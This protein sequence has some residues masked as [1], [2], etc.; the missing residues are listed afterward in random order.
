MDLQ[1]L[2]SELC[3]QAVALLNTE[4]VSGG[5]SCGCRA[6]GRAG[7][8]GR[9]GGWGRAGQVG[10]HRHLFNCNNTPPVSEALSPAHS[11]SLVD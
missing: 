4:T 9:H 10:V 2:Q 1:R 5:S 6:G 7:G 3:S 8:G 11:W